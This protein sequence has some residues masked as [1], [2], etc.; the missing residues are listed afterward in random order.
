[1]ASQ[2]SES[3]KSLI[4]SGPIT[5]V[6][7]LFAA[8]IIGWSLFWFVASRRADGAL[9]TWIEHEAAAGRSWICPDKRI[10]GYPLEIEVSCANP[11]F[12]G[13]IAGKKFTGS[14]R[15]LRV[16]SPLLRSQTLVAELEAPLIVKTSDGAVDAV[17][18]WGSLGMEFVGRPEA[19]S[20]ISL[21][22][23]QVTVQGLLGDLEKASGSASNV[24]AYVVSPPGAAPFSYDFRLTVNDA[25]APVLDSRFGLQPPVTTTIAGTITQANLAG[26]AKLQDSLEQ[27]RVAGGKVDLKT[28][29][30]AS[31]TS[32]LEGHGE[33]ALDDQHRITGNFPATIAGLEPFLQ[34]LG[35]DPTLIAAGSLVANVLGK[36]EA[37]GGSRLPVPISI[38]DGWLSI[39]PVRS[40]VQVY[41]LY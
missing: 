7:A 20:R 6:L 2:G 39:G 15:G 19:F 31:G 34:K 41:P 12:Q 29:R 30:L 27:W 14:L 36:R 37:G 26:A 9:A 11:L 35:V 18:Q 28:I 33:L 3:K 40:Q 17:A 10:S 22:G 16:A 1:M 25:Q 5:M 38:A 4:S 32:T 23:E 8:V 13:E 21:L 24:L